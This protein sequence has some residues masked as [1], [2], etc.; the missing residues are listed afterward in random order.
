MNTQELFST[1]ESNLDKNLLFEYSINK[2]V[3][4]NYHITEVKHIIVDSVDCGAQ[5]DSWNET[6][7]Q[8]WESPLETHKTEYMLVAKA[9]E[10]LKLVG[11]KKSY[12]MKALVKFEYSNASF[13]TAQL[14]VNDFSIKNGNLI[15]QLGIEKTD[16]K[17][18]ELCGVPEDSVQSLEKSKVTVDACCSPESGCC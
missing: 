12:D 15:F 16:C 17:A 18:K 6:V 1:L 14:F 2:F 5:T 7:I 4:A 8:L 13:H 3:G 10:I 9:L 11:T